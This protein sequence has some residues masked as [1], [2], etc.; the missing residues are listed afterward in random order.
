MNSLAIQTRGLFRRFGR[1]FAVDG[2]DLA[3]RP[4][5]IAALIGP[6][7]AG[8][9]TLLGLL[10]GLL[11]PSGGS[12]QILGHDSRAL[13]AEVA[14][15]VQTVG[16][17][18]EPPPHARI[19]FLAALQAEAAS[20]FDASRFR[21]L[22]RSQG[23]LSTARFGSLSKGQRR[24]VLSSLALASRPKVLLMDEPADGL[25][26]AARRAL[27]DQLRQFVNDEEATVLVS[28]H[29]L[30][31][32]ERVADEVVILRGGRVALHEWLESF[33]EE[34]RELVLA[35]DELAPEW[36]RQFRVLSERADGKSRQLWIRREAD[37]PES[38]LATA[39]LHSGVRRVNLESLYFA[40]THVAGSAGPLDR[41]AREAAPCT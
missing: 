11:A 33:R 3:I 38:A 25:D 1:K 2:V 17:R 20:Q 6:N 22:L 12:A 34:A 24:W 15:Q 30:G 27:Y 9:S 4:G 14:P 41:L 32:L 16:D 28:S 7:G 39:D 18:H 8:K 26:P 21:D 35:A 10:A 31:D 29:V 5:T 13:P 37:S 36:L 19:S 23:L 40:M